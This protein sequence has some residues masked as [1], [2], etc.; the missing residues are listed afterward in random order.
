MTAVVALLAAVVA[1]LV[2]VHR[3]RQAARIAAARLPIAN[4]YA[5]PR[6]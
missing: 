3:R 2:A 4:R 5:Y 1:A 6:R